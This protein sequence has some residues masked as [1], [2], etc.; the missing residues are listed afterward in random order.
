MSEKDIVTGQD[1]NFNDGKFHFVISNSTNSYDIAKIVK[2]KGIKWTRNDIDSAKAGRNLK[3]TMNRG[4]VCQKVKMEVSCIPLAQPLTTKLLKLINPQY[5]KVH[6]VDPLL[7]ERFVQ[8]YSNN[9]PTTFS[10]QATD[11]S[12]LWSD[13][14]FPLVER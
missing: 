11:G 6:Y 1:I 13:L 8:F 4:R 14:S 12:L 7:G 5:V 2:E 10:S 9:V 3:G